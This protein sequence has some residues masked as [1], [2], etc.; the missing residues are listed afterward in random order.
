L[1]FGTEFRIYNDNIESSGYG[2]GLYQFS[3]A[4]TQ[5]NPLVAD[6][7][8]GDEF[9][10]FL[11]GYPST[12]Q[13]DL[14]I[15]PAFQNRYYTVFTQD[16]F[17]LNDRI[18]LNMGLRWDYETPPEERYNRMV[19]GFAF[20]QP[21]P[22]AAQ[23]PG[24][25]GG[26]VYASSNDRYA[27]NPD[28]NNIQPRI[29]AAI[30]LARNW[31]VRGGYGLYYMATFGTQPT[32]GFSASTPLVS[33]ADGG[34]TPLVSLTNAFPGPLT[35]PVGSSQGLGTN[36][37]QAA[38]FSYQNRKT[39]WSHQVS[40][41]IQHVF[42][43]GIVAEATYSGNF[44]RDYPVSVELDSIPKD[45]LGMPTSYYTQQVANPLQGLL[46]L[47]PSRNGATVPRQ[48]LLV[49]FPQFTSVM[50]N[51]I[52]IGKNDFHSLQTRLAMRYKNGM[53]VNL[54]YVWSKTLEQ[55]SFLNPQ[56]FNLQ[57]IHA[58]S[59]EKRLAQFDVPQ[60]FTALWTYELPFG[61]N[62]FI[63]GNL[64]GFLDKLVSGWQVNLVGTLQSGF[65]APFPNAPNLEARS[66][67]LPSDQQTLF[68]AFDTTLF[69]KTAPN[70][71]YTYRT[72]PTRFPDVRLRA[73]T[74]LD[75][76]IS[77]KTAITEWL[78]FELRAEAYDSTNTPW[79]N[80]L[81]SQGA[82]VTSSQFGW[83]NLSSAANR[84]ITLIG[85]FIW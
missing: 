48:N 45:Q 82:D 49:P 52:P 55:M 16:D 73:L 2:G 44:T 9:A 66:A 83:Y 37:G 75:A 25:T 23:V 61:H 38:S 68:H 62:R 74:N 27:F 11:L 50:M 84:S 51:N 57:N 33:S 59:L 71:Q 24:L 54:G 64:H 79:F 31:V 19:T 46:P 28:H 78:R 10:T 85:K 15:Y 81:N 30:K 42:R 43:L 29:G 26:L 56:D 3:K 17:R 40:L 65:P 20:N 36:L 18:S 53:T 60:R 47:N 39:P 63:G 7:T 80:T 69:P 14:T 58:S 4:F 1:K 8:S 72:W 35:Q 6:S 21:S 67:E 70:L 32:T 5:A 41:G 13:V 34:L 12:G 77:K 76:S 22:L